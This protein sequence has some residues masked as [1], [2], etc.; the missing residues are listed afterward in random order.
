MEKLMSRKL[1]SLTAAATFAGCTGMA[2][3]PNVAVDIAPVHSLV[4]RVMQGVGAPNLIIQQGASPHEYNLHPSEAKALQ[5]ANLVFWMG[6]GLTPWM[7]N[8]LE[9]LASNAKIT[10]LLE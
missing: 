1:I 7:E 6:E 8:A 2:D 9:T 3:V 10:T 4:A 5:D